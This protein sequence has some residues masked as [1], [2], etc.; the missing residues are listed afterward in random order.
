MKYKVVIF[1]LDNTLIDFDAMEDGS[2][3]A[4]LKQLNVDFNPEMIDF[5][6]K[7][8]KKLWMGVENKEYLKE[9]ILTLR[10]KLLFEAYGIEASAEKMHHLF[11]D[12]MVDHLY[13]MDFS[14]EILDA[15][16]NKVVLVCLTNG[17]KK[18]QVMK[19]KKSGLDAYFDH[20][21]ISDEV[22]YHK[23]DVEIFKYMEE[24]IGKYK[25]SEMIIIG[26]SLTSDI[27]GGINYGIKTVWFNKNKI[28]YDG[29]KIFDYQIEKLSDLKDILAC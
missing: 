7:V 8:N 13:M 27:Q 11:L 29:E 23:P 24:L 17:V 19:F 20:V 25:S 9:E 21:I 15:L 6:K 5:Y 1:D 2:L 10:F 14:L 4:S 18:A 3:K 16:K 28:E 26:D 22:G 12:N